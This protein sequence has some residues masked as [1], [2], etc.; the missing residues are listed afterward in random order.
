MGA[1]KQ[2]PPP[3]LQ[4][5]VTQGMLSYAAPGLD[6]DAQNLLRSCWS[7]TASFGGFNYRCDRIGYVSERRP[8]K[9]RQ[10][11]LKASCTRSS[12]LTQRGSTRSV[13]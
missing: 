12:Q 5:H 11:G 3:T 1:G 13:P 6:C 4:L 8:S 2:H 7:T 10:E 9:A